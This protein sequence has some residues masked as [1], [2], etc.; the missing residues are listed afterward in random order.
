[1]KIN[2]EMVEVPRQAKKSKQ[3]SEGKSQLHSRLTQKIKKLDHPSNSLHFMENMQ[4]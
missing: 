2:K 3:M 4:H 1:M